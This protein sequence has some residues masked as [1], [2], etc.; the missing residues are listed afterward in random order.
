VIGG[1]HAHRRTV[2]D[3]LRQLQVGGRL[4]PDMVIA[5]AKQ[6]ESPLHAE[7]EW[8]L[9]KAAYRNWV[10]TARRLIRSVHYVVEEETVLVRVPEFVRDPRVAED[11]QGYV[12]VV[13]LRTDRKLAVE[14]M[15]DEVARVEAALRRMLRYSEVL[16]VLPDI[17]A[18]TAWARAL[19]AR[20]EQVPAG[21]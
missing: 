9:D 5:D 19:K 11:A 21:V 17:E 15:R 4:T 6:P 10:D 20:L 7:F 2:E 1:I 16:G 14:V 8:D 3:R 18:G 12:S 13:V